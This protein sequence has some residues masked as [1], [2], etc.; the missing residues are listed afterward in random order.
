MNDATQ[1][2]VVVAW[3]MNRLGNMSAAKQQSFISYMVGLALTST[4]PVNAQT[5]ISN[6]V[7]ALPANTFGAFYEIASDIEP[8]STPAPTT[9]TPTA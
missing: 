3:M 7:S 6:V 1:V 9:T 5:V 2:Q 4:P 8:L